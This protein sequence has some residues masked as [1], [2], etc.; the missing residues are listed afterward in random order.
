MQS[1]LHNRLGGL[2][3]YPPGTNQ[4]YYVKVRRFAPG[5]SNDGLTPH[6]AL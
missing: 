2:Q 6:L 3:V 5:R 1:F 4:W